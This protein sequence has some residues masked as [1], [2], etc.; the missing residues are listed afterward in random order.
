MTS[1]SNICLSAAILATMLSP[2]L[3]GCMDLR[4]IHVDEPV[5]DAGSLDVE[6]DPDA[7][8]DAPP[9]C[10]VCVRAPA[11]PGPGCGDKFATC[12]ADRGCGATMEC[13]LRKG[14]AELGDRGAIID[15]G[16]PCAAEAGLDPNGSSINLILDVITCSQTIC[17]AICRGG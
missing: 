4:V 16:A 11:D 12:V 1:K 14:C 2:G 7:A 5:S 9:P 17:G 3:A 8:A 15:C 6:H 13:A 10:E